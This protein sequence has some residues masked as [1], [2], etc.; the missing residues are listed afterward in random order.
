MNAADLESVAKEILARVTNYARKYKKE[1]AATRAAD[2][3]APHK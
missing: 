1:K 3:E 2:V